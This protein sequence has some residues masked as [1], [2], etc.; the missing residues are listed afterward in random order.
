MKKNVPRTRKLAKSEIRRKQ[1]T[2]LERLALGV[3]ASELRFQGLSFGE[4]GI[5][6]GKSKAV[7]WRA[8]GA[9]ADDYKKHHIQNQSMMVTEYTRRTEFIW[10]TTMAQYASSIPRDNQG[11]QIKGKSGNV[12]VPHKGAVVLNG[13]F[14]RM[15]SAGFIPKAKDHVELSGTPSFLFQVSEIKDKKN[16]KK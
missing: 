5:K 9:F 7:V 3:K 2:E 6:L 15:Q 1:Q 4:I 11:K 12:E 8:Y 10:R 16:E 13:M 14:D